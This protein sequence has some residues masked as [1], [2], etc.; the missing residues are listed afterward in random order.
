MKY[1]SKIVEIEAMQYTGENYQ[2]VE[3]WLV[4]LGS[5]I[6]DYLLA[7]T[8]TRLLL[9]SL[10]G[11]VNATPGDYVIVGSGRDELYP[12]GET[13]FKLKYEPVSSELV[14]GG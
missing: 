12:C 8:P 14:E 11:H 6:S 7:C 3:R 10:Q 4:S 5:F 1:K 9:C 13:A 2:E